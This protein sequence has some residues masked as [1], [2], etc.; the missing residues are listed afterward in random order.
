MALDDGRSRIKSGM[1][2]WEIELRKFPSALTLAFFATAA[3]ATPVL[4][5]PPKLIIAISV[6]QFSADLFDEYRP[7]FT[8]GLARFAAG[9]AFHN[10]YQ[11]HAATETCPGH[12]TIL[13]GDRPARTGVIANNWIDQS[14]ARD[15]K[16]VYCAEDERVPGS[17]S[18]KY[19][20]SPIHLKVPT[21]GERMKLMWPASRTVAVSGKDRAAVMMSGQRPDQRWYWAND[22]F[23]TDLKD[24]PVPAIVP[25]INTIVAAALAAELPPLETTP[26]CQAKAAPIA[27]GDSD[28]TVGSGLF[29]RNANDQAAF[30]ASPE[31]DGDTLALAAALVAEMKLGRGTAPDLLA[32]S[33]SATDYVGHTYGTEGQEMCLNLAS[34]D[35]E[36]GDFE[37]VLDR[38]GID[39]AVVLTADH[40]GLDLPERKRL[41]GDTA[42]ARVDPDLSP[43]TVGLRIVS[44]LGLPGFGLVGDSPYGDMYVDASLSPANRRKVLTAA[45]AAY[46]ANP[47]VEAVFSHGELG[48]TPLPTTT[49]DRWTLIER[50]HA[51]FDAQRSGD[52]IVL[53]RRDVT[54]IIDTS[55]YVATHG[56]AWDYDRRVPILFWRS[57]MSA[58]ASD[59]P[60]ETIDIMPTLAAW[61]GLPVAAGAIDGNCLL[62]VSGVTCPPR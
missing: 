48:A 18:N 52:F 60:I 47:Q 20:V 19:T 24:R 33:L 23:A 12:S 40:G 43:G 41:A 34:L 13:T 14:I 22:H 51:S 6:D 45:M 39:Y 46:R 15:D 10:G 27:V 16:T 26:S 62:G 56:S 1:T 42:A 17:N 28:E 35:R 4:A 55:K 5:A 49:P 53:L 7:T 59:A 31:L 29:H 11:G 9:T 21:L 44:K 25:R 38:S 58:V 57:G 32:I 2:N 54:P 37:A 3:L 50:A 30:R 61:L 8:S 36:L